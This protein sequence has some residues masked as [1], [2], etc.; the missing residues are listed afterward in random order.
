MVEK[1]VHQWILPPLPVSPLH[2]LARGGVVNVNIKW[3][4]LLDDYGILSFNQNLH[5]HIPNSQKRTSKADT[6]HRGPLWESS[7][8]PGNGVHLFRLRSYC[9]IKNR[10]VEIQRSPGNSGVPGFFVRPYRVPISGTRATRSTNGWLLHTPLTPRCPLH[11]NSEVKRLVKPASN[12]GSFPERGETFLPL[13]WLPKARTGAKFIF[14]FPDSAFLQGITTAAK[15][16]QRVS[17]LVEH[18]SR[19]Q[20][21]AGSNPA[22][23]S[24]ACTHRGCKTPSTPCKGVKLNLRRGRLFRPFANRLRVVGENGRRDLR[25]GNT[26]AARVDPVSFYDP[27]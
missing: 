16:T 14:C 12:P 9:K 4:F 2:L 22:R 11:P 27:T 21:V 26:F 6:T 8:L 3:I 13:R 24:D 7:R 10:T 1:R 19:E 17:S 15:A 5:E 25:D 20:V 23:Q 18:L